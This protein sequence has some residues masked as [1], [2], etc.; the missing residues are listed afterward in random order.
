MALAASRAY[1]WGHTTP[2]SKRFQSS[3]PLDRIPV[4]LIVPGFYANR[5][6][7]WLQH[8]VLTND[9]HANDSY[10]DAN[11]DVE[12]RIKTMARFINAPA[13]IPA[14]QPA[15]SAGLAQV[16]AS[17]LSQVESSVLPGGA[18]QPA[19]ILPP[20]KAWGGGVGKLPAVPLPFDPSTGWP[21]TWPM[22]RPLPKTGVNA[23]QRVALKVL[24]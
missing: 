1:D 4:R 12:S 13:E 3:L 8:I 20:P 21:R 17:G 16:G 22:P 5:S 10:A 18:W 15:A 11:N 24:A 23:I 2:E 19:T 7:K 9:F 6:I 14:R